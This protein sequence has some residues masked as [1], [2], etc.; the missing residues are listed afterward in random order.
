MKDLIKGILGKISKKL[1][2]KNYDESIFNTFDNDVDKK[3][4]DIE[5]L[6][7]TNAKQALDKL[8]GL[9]GLIN[10]RL[11]K[12]PS[13]FDLLEGKLH[14]IDDLAKNIAQKIDADQISI[15]LDPPPPPCGFT[16][17]ITYYSFKSKK[18]DN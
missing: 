9:F 3:I 14:K 7:D 17:T 1:D 12:R 8:G 2:E 18:E 16:V 13:I 15:T 4:A 10:D 11:N 5:D 6:I